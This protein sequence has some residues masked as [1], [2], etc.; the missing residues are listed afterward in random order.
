VIPPIHDIG[1]VAFKVLVWLLVS[2]VF[3][4]P[5]IDLAKDEEPPASVAI[6]FLIGAFASLILGVAL[7]L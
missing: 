7:W 3:L 5:T 1:V 2:Y 6:A 4:S